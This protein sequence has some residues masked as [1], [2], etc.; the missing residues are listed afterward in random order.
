MLPNKNRKSKLVYHNRTAIAR[1][2]ST[3]AIIILMGPLTAIT[4]L[5]AT[6]TASRWVR[7]LTLALALAAPTVMVICIWQIHAT[8]ARAKSL[9]N[10]YP[11]ITT[12]L[13]PQSAPS[14]LHTLS[15][16][17]APVATRLATSGNNNSAACEAI[18]NMGN[19]DLNT[20]NSEIAKDLAQAQK[21]AS[22][23][24]F[25]DAGGIANQANQL[26]KQGASN[27]AKYQQQLNAMRC[28]SQYTSQLGQVN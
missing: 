27:Q 8:T 5:I 13:T 22:I 6:A 16:S 26:G 3:S 10:H 18:V 28:S 20:L 21:D 9:E 15:A 17:T 4:K 24:N 7:G 2:I 19:K 1:T 23:G 25:S 12:A 14:S 11:P